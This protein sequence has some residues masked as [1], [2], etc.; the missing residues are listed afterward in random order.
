MGDARYD[1]VFDG[2]M[3]DGQHEEQ[4]VARLAALFKSD[5]TR[6]RRLF[7]GDRHVVKRDVDDAT[8]QKYL[9]AMARAGAIASAEARKPPQPEPDEPVDSETGWRLAPVGA[10]LLEA[11]ERPRIEPVV[12]DT[13]HLDLASVFSA[14]ETRIEPLAPAPDTSG[15]SLAETGADLQPDRPQRPA[16]AAPDTSAISLAEP[17]GLLAEPRPQAPVAIPDTDAMSLAPVGSPLEQL[18]DRRPPLDPDTSG[19]SLADSDD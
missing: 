12:V 4:V 14:P 1:I 15:F 6:I 3:G 2:E 13:S 7:D 17:G 19:L 10:D 11:E 18:T 16:P 5:E 9:M 8:A